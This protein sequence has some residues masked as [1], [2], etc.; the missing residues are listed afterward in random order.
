VGA[1]DVNGDGVAELL[2][3]AGPGAGPHVK[4]F[5]IAGGV[6]EAASFFA[7]DPAFAGGVFV[8]GGLP[9]QHVPAAA[10]LTSETRGALTSAGVSELGASENGTSSVLFAQTDGLITHPPAGARR[11]DAATLARATT[12]DL[13][14][15]ED[16]GES[17]DE[18]RVDVG[19]ATTTTG[20]LLNP[21]ADAVEADLDFADFDA[22]HVLESMPASMR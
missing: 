14:F 1:G 10:A 18:V 20:D 9:P 6:T 12:T 11:A 22:W 16:D 15:A 17:I 4:A 21:A 2:T 5:T 13:V 8:A 7:Y 3:A 19:R